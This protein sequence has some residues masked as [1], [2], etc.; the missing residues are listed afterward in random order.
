M[1]V[2]KFLLKTYHAEDVGSCFKH[3]KPIVTYFSCPFNRLNEFSSL[4]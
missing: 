3:L 4:D 2:G 1:P